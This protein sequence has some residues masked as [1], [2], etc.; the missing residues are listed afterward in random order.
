VKQLTRRVEVE[1]ELA[2]RPEYGLG[3]PLCAFR[4]RA[5]GDRWGGEPD[6]TPP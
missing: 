2:L 3:R 5:R 6:A 4:R 1:L